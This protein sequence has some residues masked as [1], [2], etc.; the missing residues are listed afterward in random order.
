MSDTPFPTLP[1]DWE[2]TRATLH[3]YSR[4]I[5]ALPQV[6]VPKHDRWWHISLKP[7]P[8]GLVTEPMGLPDGS[9]IFARLDLRTHEVV[10]ESSDG[11]TL[12]WDM[13]SGRTG[14]EMTEALIEALASRGLEGEYVRKDF[15]NDEPTSYDEAA[16]TT[17]WRALT[18]AG[19]VFSTHRA[20]IGGDVGPVQ[21]WP[22][23][24]DLAF[25]WFG[26][27]TQEYEEHGETKHLTGQLNLGFYPA[28]DAYFY[29]NPWPFD[30][31]A[32]LGKPLPE[33][34]RWM[35]AD[36]DGFD[37]TSLP[38]SAVAGD[39]AGAERVA[40]Y[41]MGVFELAAPTLKD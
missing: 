15:E 33:G 24:F 27:K 17:F 8:I 18:S 9:S 19:Q 28:G 31:S 20:A 11:Q 2:P 39:P 7:L 21:L 23:G 6:H 14:T 35:T 37:G 5:G 25:E 34:A 26:T 12:R 13:R 30:A 32:L 16:A 41:A 22:H 10:L 38:Y 3:V 4:A 1:G 29:S 40:A 36:A